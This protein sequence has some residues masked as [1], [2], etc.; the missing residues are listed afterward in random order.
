VSN[1]APQN[2]HDLLT[3]GDVA[4]QT[5]VRVA[6]LREWERRHG[7]PIPERLPSGH[8]RYSPA[9]VDQVREVLARQRT[10]LALGAAIR[11]VRGLA[12]PS[13]SVFA[14][15]LSASTRPATRFSRRTMLAISRAIE[16]AVAATGEHG[17]L[18]GCFQRAD[19]FDPA[20]ARWR[21]LARGATASVVL[22]DF[23]EARI[24]DGIVEVPIDEGSPLLRE[25]SIAVAS[26][27]L[28]A[29]LVGWE[30]LGE[31]GSRF[32]ALWSVDS[33]VVDATLE[34][35]LAV[36]RQTVD[37]LGDVSL[38]SGSSSDPA[39]TQLLMDRIVARLDRD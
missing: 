28:R 32:E 31:R 10:G 21:E 33:D 12:P 13:A 30:W 19:R 38:P 23:A 35:G 15:A 22:A 4:S 18:V 7:F 16:D 17:V 3:I 26:P 24:A 34:R 9:D 39:L 8:R 27:R 6:T 1:I 5:G 2:L 36:A 29:C 37:T 14:A 25:W 11:M 20:R